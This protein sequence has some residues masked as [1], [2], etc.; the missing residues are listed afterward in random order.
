MGHQPV[1]LE[2]IGELL[3]WDAP[4][5]CYID[6]TVGGGGHSLALLESNPRPRKILLADQD[7]YALQMAKESLKIFEPIDW[8]HT[9]FRRLASDLPADSIDRAIVDLGVSSFQLDEASRGFSFQKEGPLDMRMNPSE[10]VPA[11][12]FLMTIEEGALSKILWEWGEER[13]SRRLARKWVEKRAQFDTLTTSQFVE[14]LGFSLESRDRRG[15][16]PLTRVFQALRIA[17]N[18]EMGALQDLM[19]HLPR[20]L[21]KGGRVGILTFH[22]LEDREVKWSLREALKP[23]NKKVII[24][25][26]DEMERNPR[27]R[28]AK[29]RVFEKH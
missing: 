15:R 24:A 12:E 2:P 26:E 28:S 18:D 19:S 16:H 25:T 4:I 27:S 9:N 29:L 13:Q 21:K 5:E 14:A 17:V 3:A 10:G 6:F 7:P 1:L 20:I 8:K 11:S 23:I 22:S